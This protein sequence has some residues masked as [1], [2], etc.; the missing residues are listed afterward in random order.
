MKIK[1]LKVATYIA[2]L[3]SHSV[4]KMLLN[5]ELLSVKVI[6]CFPEEFGKLFQIIG[7]KQEILF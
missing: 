5:S 3:I 7:V 1:K 4:K 2:H 6:G